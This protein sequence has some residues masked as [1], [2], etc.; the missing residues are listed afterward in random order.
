[1][2]ALERLISGEKLFR[3][4]ILAIKVIVGVYVQCRRS[5]FCEQNVFTRQIVKREKKTF[6]VLFYIQYDII[7]YYDLRLKKKK[8]PIGNR[9]SPVIF[10]INIYSRHSRADEINYEPLGRYILAKFRKEVSTERKDAAP[11]SC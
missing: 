6:F 10:D 1:M 8:K 5:E 9:R 4:S 7:R 3:R 11:I 2:S